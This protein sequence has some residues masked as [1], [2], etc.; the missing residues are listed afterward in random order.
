MSTRPT[1]WAGALSMD[2]K[3]DQ[4][5]ETVQRLTAAGVK[6]AARKAYQDGRLTAQH[7]QRALRKCSYQ[8]GDYRCV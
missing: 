1:P 6:A 3:P 8:V 4:K 5:R 2:A 7:P